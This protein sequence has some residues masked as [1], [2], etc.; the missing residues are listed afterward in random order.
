MCGWIGRATATYL[1]LRKWPPR[2][3]D[4]TPCEFYLRRHVDIVYRPSLPHDLQELR[5]RII[6]AVTAI[7]ED[8]L[9]E[10]WQELDFRLDVCRVTRGAHIECL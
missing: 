6:I 5:K 4:L 1:S 3:P 7:K 10:V 8:L 9:E 2:S